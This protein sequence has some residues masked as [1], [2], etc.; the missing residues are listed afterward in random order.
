MIRFLVL[1]DDLT[2]AAD[3]AV[4]FAGCGLSAIVALDDG[5]DCDAEVLA[6]D[7]NTRANEPHEAASAMERLI[8]AHARGDDLLIY[9]KI[10]STLRGNVAAELKALLTARNSVMG[11]GAHAVAVLAPAF[12]ATGRTTVGGRPLVN[13]LSLSKTDLWQRERKS[14]PESLIEMMGESGLRPALVELSAI[15]GNNL[16]EIVTK[17][18]READVLVCDA[19]TEEDLHAIACA[20]MTLGCGAVWVGSAGLASHLPRAAGLQREGAPGPALLWG[21][22]S[23]FVVGSGSSVSRQ[24]ARLLESRPDVISLR[25]ARGALRGGENLPEWQAHRAALERAFSAGV[26]VLLT[27]GADES[28]EFEQEPLLAAAM[29][30]MLRPFSNLVGA[31]VITG[32]ETARAVFRAWEI[33]GMQILGEV[34]PGLPF[35]ITAGWSRQLPVLTKAG[36]FGTPG[37]L[38]H[39][40]EFLR[41]RGSADRA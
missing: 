33:R 24:Q 23:L 12:P 18:A 19:E 28:I 16:R 25:I 21:G 41:A 2:G 6:I 8:R 38:L 22:P 3:C 10:D 7:A 9:K 31:L 34:E 11:E 26:D 35:S 4:A 14:P 5:R 29:G 20:S 15:R 30:E 37:T 27:L 36:G 40:R 17:L 13:G 39:C 32:G 1:A